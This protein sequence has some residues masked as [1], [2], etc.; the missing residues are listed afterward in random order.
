MS[1]MY[2]IYIIPNIN[3]PLLELPSEVGWLSSNT[4]SK[5]KVY[6]L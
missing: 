3:L 1:V 5:K 4:T 6:F 2:T